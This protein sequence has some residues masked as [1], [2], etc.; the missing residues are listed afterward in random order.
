[1]ANLIEPGVD[2]VSSLNLLI[3]Y[4]V[5]AVFIQN[6]FPMFENPLVK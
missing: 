5:E 1:M 2:D 6:V 3:F 4:V